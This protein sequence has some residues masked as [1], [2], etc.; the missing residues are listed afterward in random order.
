MLTAETEPRPAA[1]DVTT[2][3]PWLDICAVDDI[4]P[5]TGV[6]ALVGKRQIAIFRVGADDVYA[7]SNFDPFGKAFVL[8][9]GIVGDKGG[10]PKVTSPLYKQGFDLRTGASL[11]DASVHVPRYPVRVRQGRVELQVAAAAASEPGAS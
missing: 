1:G 4:I 9:R 6:C 2:D 3:G 7:L 5:N 8:S 10:V 11:D